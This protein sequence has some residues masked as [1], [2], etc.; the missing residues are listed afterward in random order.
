MFHSL[1]TTVKVT[2]QHQDSYYFSLMYLP[3]VDERRKALAAARAQHFD[4]ARV[5]QHHAEGLATE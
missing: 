1:C 2:K 4:W 5:L 3:I